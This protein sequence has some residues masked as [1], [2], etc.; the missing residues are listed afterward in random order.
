MEEQSQQPQELAT[1]PLSPEERNDLR[2]RVLRG[3]RLS[4]EE[5]RAVYLTLR[6]SQGGVVITGEN[7]PKRQS[8]KK[9]AMDDAALEASLGEFGI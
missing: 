1:R 5:A 9:Q 6:S 8:K 4:V 2:Q 3:E 7:K